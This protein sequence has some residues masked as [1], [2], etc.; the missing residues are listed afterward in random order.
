MNRQNLF[1]LVCFCSLL[2]AATLMMSGC[3]NG[4]GFGVGAGY[5]AV[6]GGGGTGPP[7]FVGSP[8]P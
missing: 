2:V 3:V 4:G 6:W 7:I 8:A 5:P 1:A